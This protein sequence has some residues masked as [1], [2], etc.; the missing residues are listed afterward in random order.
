MPLPPRIPELRALDLLESV[1]RL[2]SLGKAAAEH[3]ITQPAVSVAVRRLERRLGVPLLDRTPSGSKLTAEGAMVVDW[4][5]SVLDSAR[6]LDAG[7]AALRR[8]RA[9]KVRVAASLTIAE[10][11][12][13]AW[14]VRWHDAHPDLSI[15]LTVDNSHDVADRVLDGSSDLGFVEGPRVA[16]GLSSRVVA[17]DR[18]CIVVAPGHPWARR[19]RPLRIADVLA[20]QFVQR[21]SGSGTRETWE[22]AI[23]RY[24]ELAPAM[25]EL[26][27]TTA[28][29]STV[30]S[31]AGP[32]VLS[33]LAVA[34]DVAAGRLVDVPL[35]EVDLE[36]ALRVVW[37]RGRQ[38]V[39]AARDLVAAL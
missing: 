22:R 7:V 14:L 23:A 28:I 27:S 5:R 4:A 26:S 2:G 17:R 12:I 15:A 24:G 11:L 34:D 16:A 31:G 9:S 1:A 19:R 21:E 6:E 38:I 18:L 29:K 36:R 37:P 39:G 10:Y 33:S 32:A 30:M 20:A 3:G 35:E 13:P 8:S 25:I